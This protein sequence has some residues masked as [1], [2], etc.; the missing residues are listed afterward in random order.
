MCLLSPSFDL[1]IDEHSSHL[2]DLTPTWTDVICLFRYISNLKFSSQMLHS[3][4]LTVRSVFLG[5]QVV[6]DGEMSFNGRH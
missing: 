1:E 6:I 4:G 3:K 2:N 5:K